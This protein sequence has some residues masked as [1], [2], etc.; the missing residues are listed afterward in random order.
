MS[1]TPGQP[2][3]SSGDIPFSGG[4]PERVPPPAPASP[5]APPND[6]LNQEWESEL[7]EAMAD[8]GCERLDMLYADLPGGRPAEPGALI[9]AE[10]VSVSGEDVFVDLGGKHQGVVA[11]SQF[12][13]PPGVGAHLELLVDRFDA[14]A[15]LLILS[16]EGAIKKAAW[17]SLAVGT[18]VEGRVT[19]MNKGGL[20]VDLQGIRAFMPASQVDATRMQD[21]SLLIGERVRCEVIELDRRDKSVLVSRR[22]VIEAERAAARDKLLA[23]L[24]AGQTRQGVVTRLLDFGAFV[25]LGGVEGL[26][27]ISDM[28]W[29]RL[30]EAREA[31]QPG[32]S[33][34]VKVLKFDAETGRISLG[35]KQLAPDP[36]EQVARK[37]PVGSR[38]KG[39][40][41]RLADF[42]AFVELEPGVDGLIPISELSWIKRLRHPAEVVQEGQIVEVAVLRVEPDK[43]RVSLGMKQ[44]EGDPWKDA[45]SDF[46]ENSVVTGKV[47]R[48]A[49]FGAFVELR[50]GVD[51]LVHI[52]ELSDKRVKSPREV[53]KEGD[54]VRVRVLSVDEKQRRISLSMKSLEAAAAPVEISPQG[55]RA[56]RKHKKPLRGGLASH[57]E[58]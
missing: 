38:L 51:G 40:V 32:Q 10:V 19:G 37:Y 29:S 36:W 16:R 52:S 17:D 5:P 15:G 12:K 22:K 46:R 49:E 1:S 30:H 43:K 55:D 27:H 28:S 39:R 26:L 21:I 57:F 8:L 58:W 31:V 23:E 44:I 11:R 13:E 25:D 53:V 4:P 42:G 3:P 50:P 35:L 54:E 9:R 20:E 33:L 47:C 14:D 56:R 41:T 24:E 48:L 7:A 34:K 6:G 45:A 2:G 18:L